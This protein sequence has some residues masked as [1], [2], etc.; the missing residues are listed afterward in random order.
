[1]NIA[2]QFNLILMKWY[3]NFNKSF[4]HLNKCDIHYI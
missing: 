3:L 1:M 4:V 2:D